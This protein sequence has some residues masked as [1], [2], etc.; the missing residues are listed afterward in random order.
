MLM[1]IIP[2]A[3]ALALL[4]APLAAQQAGA[5]P[6]KPPAQP[7][8]QPPGN[9]QP[10][11]QPAA[12]GEDPKAD[13]AEGDP[14]K[15]PETTEEVKVLK[16][17][18]V[19]AEV[20]R[21]E[22]RKTKADIK[23]EVTMVPVHGREVKVKGVVCNGKLIERFAG[24]VFVADPTIEHPQCG[25]RLWWV[26]NTAGWIFIRYS[27]IRTIALTGVLTAEEK[28]KIMEALRV[29]EEEKKKEQTKA[30][31]AKLEEELLQL[32]QADLEAYLLR[33]YPQDQ[34]WNADRLKD[35]KKK[36]L[37]DNQPLTRQESIFVS[38]FPV[39][40]KARVKDLKRQKDKTEFE[41][42]S[43]DKPQDPAGT[44]PAGSQPPKGDRGGSAAGDDQSDDE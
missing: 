19:P 41:P 16:P 36:Q 43:A 42:G 40:I 5:Q 37:I 26:D 10:G 33:E 44:P 6:G 27:Q 8:K 1:R 22:K 28:R 17:G 21:I 39:L 14:A 20:I 2:G 12:G 9:A 25:V 18:D 7:G 29:K 31:D 13:P 34:N 38:Y 35:L 3:F 32:S 24:R 15:A 30:H 23:C 4:C 11:K